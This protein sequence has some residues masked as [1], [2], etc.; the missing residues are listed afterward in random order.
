MAKLV[1]KTKVQELFK[2]Y[3]SNYNPEDP[4]ISLKI[5][6]THRVAENSKYIATKLNLYEEE[7]E[8]AWLIGMLHD[9]GRF[10]QIKRFGT[11]NDGISVD[12]GEF[13]A[14][15]LFKDRLIEK[16]IDTRKYDQV[17]ETAIRQHN[18]Y[19]LREGLDSK[20][21]LFSNIIRDADKVDIFRVQVEEPIVGIYGIPLEDI[22]KQTLSDAVFDQFKEH[23]AILRDLKKTKL[24]YYVSHF[25]LAFELVYPCSK[26]L[27]KEQG[28]L[29]KLMGLKVENPETQKQ[30]DFIKKEINSVL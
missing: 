13:G 29:K 26:Q 8:I 16:Y 15:L 11:F 10:E 30:I 2:S 18:K 7:I 12:H 21:E 20:T 23:T 4:K 14:D 5:Y 1:N 19:R 9:I 28:Y 27:T 22:Q 3:T 25:S 6:H 17:I 24:D